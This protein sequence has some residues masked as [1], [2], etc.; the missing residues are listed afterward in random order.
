VLSETQMPSLNDTDAQLLQVVTDAA[1]TS[2]DDVIAIMK[3]IDDVLPGN[4]GL[5]WFNKLYLKVT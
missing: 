2:I 4:D 5:K 1:P 3:K